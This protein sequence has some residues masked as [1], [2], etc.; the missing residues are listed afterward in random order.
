MLSSSVSDDIFSSTLCEMFSRINII[1]PPP[2]DVL[3]SLTGLLKPSIEN[4]IDEKLSSILVSVTTS[5]SILSLTRHFN[6][7][8]SS[9]LIDV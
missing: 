9:Q 6:E 3:S 5:K 2:W 4:C 1:I 8:N 7:S